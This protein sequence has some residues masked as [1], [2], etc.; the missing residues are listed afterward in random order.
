MSHDSLNCIDLKEGDRRDLDL[1]SELSEEVN[2]DLLK[3]T[4]FLSA[5]VNSIETY[6]FENLVKQKCCC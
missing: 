2:L 6:K 3:N 5:V 4:S 1:K